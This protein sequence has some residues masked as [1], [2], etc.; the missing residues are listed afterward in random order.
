MDKA[1]NA[2]EKLSLEQFRFRVNNPPYNDSLEGFRKD[3]TA[4]INLLLLIQEE[5]SFS[6][7]LT[8]LL[9][10]VW[11]YFSGWLNQRFG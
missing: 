4:R 11:R 8:S 2:D 7:R 3:E 9:L 1:E 6:Q 5:R 10:K